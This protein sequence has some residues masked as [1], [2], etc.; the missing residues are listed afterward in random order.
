MVNAQFAFQINLHT[1]CS[2]K[3]AF[4]KVGIGNT[5]CLYCFWLHKMYFV[6]DIYIQNVRKVR[7][8]LSHANKT[9]MRS[10]IF[11]HY[12]P[13]CSPR[14]AAQFDTRFGVPDT[15]CFRVPHGTF[16]H[17]NFSR[18]VSCWTQVHDPRFIRVGRAPQCCPTPGCRFA[19]CQSRPNHPTAW[20][21]K[22]LF[23][24]PDS[25]TSMLPNEPRSRLDRPRDLMWRRRRKATITWC[26]TDLN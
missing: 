14:N 12:R 13:M 23:D 20:E 1:Q 25:A 16:A 22:N 24:W 18:S 5:T 3:C 26:D 21:W 8:H 10:T 7:L 17:T 19:L 11:F 15:W 2:K 9:Q 6:T 4:W